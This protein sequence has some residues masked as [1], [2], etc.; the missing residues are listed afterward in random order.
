MA[1]PL[2]YE[3]W[4]ATEFTGT[5]E[6]SQ[7]A[8]QEY[9]KAFSAA[10]EAP[11][12]STP[13]FDFLRKNSSNNFFGQNFSENLNQT[14]QNIKNRFNNNGTLNFGQNNPSE[15]SP[16]QAAPKKITMMD[17]VRGIAG[18]NKP[19]YQEFTDL[20][21]KYGDSDGR[22]S[23][24]DRKAMGISKRIAR[25]LNGKG[26]GKALANYTNG[27]EKRSYVADGKLFTE[28]QDGWNKDAF[29]NATYKGTDVN[30]I[31]NR[32]NQAIQDWRKNAEITYDPTTNSYRTTGFGGKGE[33]DITN[34]DWFKNDVERQKG[35]QQQA[36]FN[37]V[38]NYN[39]QDVLGKYSYNNL[40]GTIGLDSEKYNDAA[41][42]ALKTDEEKT[43]YRQDV[44][45]Q[46]LEHLDSLRNSQDGSF[47]F[48]GNVEAD[49]ILKSLINNQ[50]S[51]P[52]WLGKL[53]W[54]NEGTYG[55]M[56]NQNQKQGAWG[57]LAKEGAVLKY[58][59]KHLEGDSIKL[60][61]APR[62][63][64]W[65]FGENF[66]ANETAGVNDEYNF[67]NN[68]Y[69]RYSTPT[70]GVYMYVPKNGGMSYFEEDGGL[71]TEAGEI[72][73]SAWYN[74]HDIQAVYDNFLDKNSGILRRKN[75]KTE[76]P[77]TPATPAT[78]K[79]N[80]NSGSNKQES[81]PEYTPYEQKRKERY[82]SRYA[83]AS[84]KNGGNLNMN[85]I[86]YFQEGGAMAP[87]QAAP[88]QG[89]Q[90]IQSQVMQL[91]QA[92]MSGDQQA[93]DAINQIMQAA[94]QGDQQ[95]A[96]IAQ[97]IQEV[98]Q[99]MQGQAQ[100]AKRGAKLSYLHSLKTGCPEGTEAKYY[101]K[102]GQVCKECV[103]K[104]QK[105]DQAPKASKEKKMT[106]GEALQK[107][108]REHPYED[109]S[110]L[111]PAERKT[112]DSLVVAAK[113]DGTYPK[114]VQEKACGGKAKKHQTGGNL[115]NLRAI[116]D[117]YKSK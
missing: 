14:V 42:N 8:Y 64:L 77:E 63:K 71:G 55:K 38:N 5:A 96:Q 116:F 84:Y 111:T 39:N 95:A 36:Y 73:N 50:S 104:A 102:G 115:K 89:G 17:R 4:M 22:I 65:W 85:N 54:S 75:V 29:D 97:L 30:D 37:A 15:V 110:D 43:K 112:Q 26:D 40:L 99:Q 1:Q 83:Y 45:E 52:E 11:Q 19:T 81:I 101:K 25:D 46:L 80:P 18:T 24:S 66:D 76:E 91:V 33:V 108:N 31:T 78:P 10:N 57:L 13:K 60:T 105:G 93:T 67:N 28:G 35:I 113:K 98:A 94:Q 70:S 56:L 47:N 61:K 20:V 2:S 90:D 88:A 92:A 87:A 3:D 107:F 69:Y 48:N 32:Y 100:A 27:L 114:K 9:V 6:E 41:Y 72:K 82:H 51:K 68:T 53:S 62:K 12:S 49:A 74:D 103:K 23:R 59:K 79:E 21:K 109:I 117:A 16:E 106:S 44:T 34:S 86:K 58:I 7:P